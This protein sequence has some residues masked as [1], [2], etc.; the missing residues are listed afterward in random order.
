MKK[1]I[2][3]MAIIGL[4]AACGGGEKEKSGEAKKEEKPVDNSDNPDY[5]KGL[6]VL[7]RVT[8]CATCHKIDEKNIGPAWKDVAAKYSGQDTSFN[9]LVNKITNGGSG[10]WGEVAMPPNTAVAKEDVEALAKYILLLK[11]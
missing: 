7:N 10:V 9:Y 2:F 5:Q 4:L 6:E 3:L 8:I 1:A 11:K